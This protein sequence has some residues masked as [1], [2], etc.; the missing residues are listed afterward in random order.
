[1]VGRATLLHPPFLCGKNQG[2][3]RTGRC[4]SAPCPAADPVVEVGGGW[5]VLNRVFM[6]RYHFVCGH[7]VETA[8]GTRRCVRSAEE[9][10]TPPFPAPALPGVAAGVESQRQNTP[11]GSARSVG[12]GRRTWTG[13]GRPSWAGADDPA[14]LTLRFTSTFPGRVKYH[15]GGTSFRSAT[16]KMIRQA[17]TNRRPIQRSPSSTI[18]ER[19]AG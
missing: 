15:V 13:A 1:M 10:P 12:Q 16:S 2:R 14:K 3:C 4:S 9:T 6:G 11:H 18:T 5:R 8:V 7:M 17:S 19:A